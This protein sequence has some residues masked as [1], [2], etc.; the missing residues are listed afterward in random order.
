M[1]EEEKQHCTCRVGDGG[2]DHRPEC[3][4]SQ[5][6][7]EIWTPPETIDSSTQRMAWHLFLE[8]W[9]E[10]TKKPEELDLVVIESLYGYCLG[11]AKIIREAELKAG[12][13]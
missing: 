1:T 4:L 11:A 3:P 5:K 6:Q 7:T 8:E 12:G 13:Q 9:K 10:Q 2:E